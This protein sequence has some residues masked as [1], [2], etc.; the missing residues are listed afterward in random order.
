M[1]IPKP[2]LEDCLTSEISASGGDVMYDYITGSQIRRVHYFGNTTGSHEFEIYEGCTDSTQLF[3]VGGGGAGGFGERRT[4]GSGAPYF[5]SAPASYIGCANTATQTGGGGGAGGVLLINPNRELT[6]S[7][8]LVP[9]RYPIY[10]G[11]GGGLTLS[12]D[13]STN[14]NTD[15]EDTTLRYPFQLANNADL[16]SGS[17]SQSRYD[18]DSILIKGGGGGAGGNVTWQTTIAA[19]CGSPS[20]TPHWQQITSVA[21]D[22][23]SGGG[24]SNTYCGDGNLYIGESGSVAFPFRNQGFEGIWYYSPSVTSP[25]TLAGNG[26]GG[27]SGSTSF[28]QGEQTNGGNGGIESIRGYSQ[29]YGVGGN[30]QDSDDCGTSGVVESG[31]ARDLFNFVYDSGSQMPYYKGSGGQAYVYDFTSSMTQTYQEDYFKGVSGEA[32]ITYALTGSQLTNGKLHYIDGGA[33][34]GIFT[35]VPCGEVRLE[36]LV[37]PPNKQA[38]ICAMDTGLGLYRAGDYNDLWYDSVDLQHPTASDYNWEPSKMLDQLPS[39]SGTVTFTTGSSCKAYVPFEGW[40]TCG[41]CTEQAPAGI[42]IGFDITGS[43]GRTNPLPYYKYPDTTIHYTSSQNYITE[44]RYNNHDSESYYQTRIGAFSNDYDDDIPYE[45]FV[46]SASFSTSYQD[47]NVDFTTGS[48]CFTYYDCDPIEF[49]PLTASGGT[50]GTFE[51]GSFIYKYHI[52]SSSGSANE[53]FTRSFQDFTITSGYSDDVNVVVIGP[54]GPGAKGSGSY[55]SYA[56]FGGGGGAG[57]VKIDKLG[58][59]CNAYTLKIAPGFAQ[60]WG[61]DSSPTPDVWQEYYG[62]TII[63]ASDGIYYNTAGI[64]G[65]GSSPGNYAGNTDWNDRSG[66]VGGG[67]SF[68]NP[69]GFATGSWSTLSNYGGDGW[70]GSLLQ[71]TGSAGGGGGAGED[72]F[73]G[74]VGTSAKGGEGG[75]GLRLN[76]DGSLRY[77]AGGG[78]GFGPGGPSNGG[79]GGGANSGIGL[80]TG[81]FYGGGGGAWIGATQT[82]VTPWGATYT[83]NGKG[84]DGAVIINYKWKWNHTQTGSLADRGLSQYYDIYDLNSYNGT[85]SLVYSLWKNENTA[86]LGN[87]GGWQYNTTVLDGSG[88]LEVV[89]QSLHPYVT[90]ETESSQSEISVVTTWFSNNVTYDQSSSS[91]P[92]ISD[93]QFGTSSFGMYAGDL[94]T[95]GEAVVIRIGDTEITTVSGSAANYIPR[96]GFHISQFS[97]NQ[98]TNEL[99]WYVDGYSGSATVNENINQDILL[100][101]NSSSAVFNPDTNP[102]YP[103]ASQATQYKITKDSSYGNFSFEFVYPQTNLIVS[104]SVT[105][106]SPTSWIFASTQIPQ[107]T[108]GTGTIESGSSVDYY[109][110]ESLYLGR[111][112]GVTWDRWYQDDDTYSIDMFYSTTTCEWVAIDAQLRIPGDRENLNIAQNSYIHYTWP[113][114][115]GGV[116]QS[117]DTNVTQSFQD[118]N[119][120]I[121]RPPVGLGDD[122]TFN[123]TAI[124]TASLDWD[125]M[126]H[127]DNFLYPR[128]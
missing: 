89:T 108:N 57:Q 84:S 128:Y 113:V 74:T 94:E 97:Y 31:D 118:Y 101:F 60:P 120:C 105:N 67:A 72:G 26:G 93:E 56:F 98:N 11:D 19:N 106:A 41:P 59:L 96:Q 115:G 71:A 16:P 40:E 62:Q 29:V 13:G 15:G 8:A 12:T 104:R 46:P 55:N 81:S 53:P 10:I 18:Y 33:S 127:N 102:V 82:Y 39:G 80:S 7:L 42:Y 86:S 30:A 28:P 17:L 92:I 88:S 103:S 35:F 22:G 49:L 58:G 27:Y 54:G 69:G 109:P 50:E 51:S 77:Y 79:L 78:A 95:Y 5:L 45:N 99:L 2:A 4:T 111:T 83:L 112:A 123:L 44:S 116:T 61:T 117:L 91:Y 122:S 43:S 125:E 85:G 37:V 21:G 6:G 68:Y 66:S 75:K 38:C 76:L 87:A 63:S 65:R 9:G 64:G 14:V 32:I 34:G 47:Q 90:T 126:R 124:Y 25:T 73:D 70:S 1:Y 114:T 100:S 3:L 119:D 107:I 23:G 110:S 48:Q 20:G 52:F 121:Y 24:A 36:T